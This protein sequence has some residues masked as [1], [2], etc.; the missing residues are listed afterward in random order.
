MNR[1]KIAVPAGVGL[2]AAAVGAALLIGDRSA[3]PALAAPSEKEPVAVVSAPARPP[4]RVRAVSVRRDTIERG[5]EV[6]GV[7]NA[8][9]KSTISA[10]S[11]G[12]VLARAAESGDAVH[13][14]D[15]LLTLDA[16]RLALAVKEARANVSA[17]KVDVAEAQQELERGEQLARGNTISKSRF[18]SLR[19]GVERAETQ[20]ELAHV[21]LA[22]AQRAIDDATIEAPFDGSVEEMMV[23]VGDYLSPGTP[24][25]VLVDLSRARVRAGVTA[26]EARGL[27]PDAEV[28]VVFADLGS[29]EKSGVIRSI[30]R[31]ADEGTGTYTVEVWVEDPD[32]ELRDGMV[33]RVLLPRA[34]S[35]PQPVVPRAA[36]IRREGLISLIVVDEGVARARTVRV[37]RSSH[38]LVE[39]LEEVDVGDAVVV[40]GLFALRDGAAVS[41]EDTPAAP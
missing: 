24:V 4:L 23:D 39:I 15:P 38:D 26:A 31:L 11:A 7:V 5:G 25:A 3:S 16:T 29:R 20:L 41:V 1:L 28:T 19:F 10:E 36:L 35:D 27:A 9:R 34:A 21:N 13:A 40:D 32:A 8:F 14:G 12:R 6:S 17:R 37:G 2:L 30:G 33:A 22:T 18:D